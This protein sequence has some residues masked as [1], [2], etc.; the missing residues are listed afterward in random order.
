MSAWP[1]GARAAVS[2][3]L[4]N[5][6]EAAEIQLGLRD[7][8]APLGGHYSVTTAL[9][10]VL[11]AL[12]EARLRAT[13]FVEGV[14][15]EI[16]PDALHAISEAGHELAYHAW[17]HEDWSALDADAEAA[18][19]DRGLAAL[20]AIGIDAAGLRPPGGRLTPR[21]LELLARR[22]LRY[23]SPAGSTPGIEHGVV[24]LPFE[25]RA[26]DAF[27]LLPSFGSLREHVTGS[28]DAGGA[29]A[30]RAALERTVEDALAAGGHAVLV[31]HTWMI[32]LELDAVRDVLAHVGGEVD[33]GAL[34]AAPCRDVATWIAEHG[35]SFADRPR[36]DRTSWTAPA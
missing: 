26:V 19:L 16:Y 7:A 13:F 30:V 3:T 28:P 18:N 11:D 32:E 9:P 21:T 6:G 1:G 36:L 22:A 25:W 4:D 29:E 35:A 10:I 27:H 20:R 15:A 8:D 5:L 12:A 33:A 34:W 14:N 17:C 2:I 23:C 24:V 31:L